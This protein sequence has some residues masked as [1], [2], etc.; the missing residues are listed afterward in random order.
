ME[1]IIKGRA[2]KIKRLEK[3]LRLR[4]KRDGL[5][6]S[7]DVKNIEVKEPKEVKPVIKNSSKKGAKK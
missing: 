5:K 1:L 2:D 6:A 7:I 4:F 3:E